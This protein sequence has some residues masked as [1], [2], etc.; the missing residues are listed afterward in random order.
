MINLNKVILM[1][2]TIGVKG[3]KND[4]RRSLRI[5]KQIKEKLKAYQKE[6]YEKELHELEKKVSLIQKIT[7]IKTLPIV[8]A[9][10][11]YQTLTQDNEKKKKLALQEVTKRL[12]RENSFSAKEKEE[13]I[14]ALSKYELFSLDDDL[15]GKLG[16]SHEKDEQVSEIDLTLFTGGIEEPHQ[17][18]EEET[19]QAI[20]NVVGL[21]KEEQYLKD[22]SIEKEIETK[23]QDKIETVASEEKIEAG[24]TA[25]DSFNDQLD[26][27]KNHKIVAEYEHKLKDVRKEL[28]QLIFEYNL[29][30]DEVEYIYNS[31][32]AEELLDRLNAIIKKVEELKKAIAVPDVDKYDDNYLYILIEDYMESFN[33]QKFV[34]E[35]KDSNLYIMLSNKLTEL[36]TKKDKLQEKIE[37]RKE[38]LEIDEEHLEELKERYFDFEKFNRDLLN[39]QVAQDSVLDEINKKMA[40]ATTITER[41][42]AQTRGMARQSRRLMRM[43]GAS[44]LLPGARSARSMATLTATYLYFMRN[45][46]R[47][48]TVTKRYKVVKTTDYHKEIEKSLQQLDDVSGLLKKTSRQL[49]RTIEEVEKEFAEYMGII[50]ECKELIQNLEKV[51]DEIK[52]KEYELE[53]IKE[54]QQRNLEKNDAKVKKLN[55]E[56]AV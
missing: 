4:R 2:E 50:P 31:K 18:V 11:V 54:E 38:V 42:E 43:I 47:P 21:Q 55:Y 28:R 29:I 12:E 19:K 41:V 32:E 22:N 1:N 33:N 48:H 13:I 3:G 24:I 9:G 51:K 15:L 49:E 7:F 34:S 16:I 46:M 17:V 5:S 27:L 53:R 36:D 39:F 37:T 25:L 14:S 52:E 10:Q 23:G 56:T 8:I 45:V 40:E 30:A 20:L 26:K 35:I 6:Q 44:M